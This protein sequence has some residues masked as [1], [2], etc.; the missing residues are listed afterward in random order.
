MSIEGKN[1]VVSGGSRGIGKAVVLALAEQG[2]NVAFTFLNHHE[3]ANEVINKSNRL[4]GTVKAYQV[5]IRDQQ[6][7]KK[8]IS[9]FVKENGCIDVVVNNAGIRQDK[10][11]AFMSVENWNNVLDTN[12]NGAFYLTQTAIFHM[13]KKKSGRIIFISSISGIYGIPGQVNYSSAK[14]ALIGLTRSLA[15]EVAQYGISVNAIAPGG[16]DTDMVSSM[17]ENDKERL[18][19]GVPLG[20]MCRTDEV[21]RVVQFLAD[22]GGA[23]EY[24]TGTVIPLDGG[25]GL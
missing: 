21:A 22:D 25:L 3:A 19:Q 4:K 7:V 6:Q 13:L 2:A 17:N 18:L 8:M 10:S 24:L 23:P 14:A 15:K 9:E 1:I 16:V 11:V 20:R 12:L 5:D